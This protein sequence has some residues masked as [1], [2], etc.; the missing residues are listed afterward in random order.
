M[1]LRRFTSLVLTALLAACSSKPPAADTAAASAAATSPEAAEAAEAYREARDVDCQAAGGTLQRLGRLQREQCV[2]PYADA[3]KA[4]SRKS[5]CMGQ[6]LAGSE[7]TVG[8]VATGTCQRDVR[9]NFGCRQRIDEGKAQGMI[10]V[11]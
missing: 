3:G 8:S 5:D 10:C 2:I 7:V 1:R 6:C 9:Q 4:C 11:D